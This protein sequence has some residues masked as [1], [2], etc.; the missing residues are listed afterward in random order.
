[1]AWK[2]F[3]RGKRKKIDVQIFE[4]NLEDNLFALHQKLAD[5]IYQHGNYTSF[6]ITDPKRRKIHKACVRDRV[7]HHAVYRILYP[8]FDKSFIYDSYSCRLKKGTYKAIDRLEI[9]VRKISKNYFGK[10]F[11]LK[12][13]IKKFFASVDQGILLK[14]IEGKIFDPETLWLVREIIESFNS[15]EREYLPAG[16][17]ET[18]LPIGNLTSQLFANIYLNQ[19][20]QFIKHQFRVKYYT[21]YTDDF[22]IISN[23]A[24]FLTSLIPKIKKFLLD[25]LKL[26]LHP[27]KIIIRKLRQGVDF[28]GY[29]VLPHYRILRTKTKKRMLKRIDQKNLASYL[30]LLGHCAADKL[31]NSINKICARI[32]V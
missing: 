30:G 3:R 10:C 15:R 20:D 16:R 18:G 2:E 6:Y 25:N 28:L 22:V 14:I 31:R 13:D 24:E 32:R 1:L 11:V 21:R 19:F 9:F 12:C 29:V 4:R 23:S 27:D 17:Q 8:I 7:L 5:G 26:E